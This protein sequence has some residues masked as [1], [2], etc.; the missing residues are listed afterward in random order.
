MSPLRQRM[1][2]DMQIRNFSPH[3]RHQYVT[4]VAA[5][6]KH[7]GKSPDQIGL[8]EIRSYQLFL[9][10]DKGV[11]PATLN[12]AVSALR[13]LYGVTLKQDWDIQMIPYA[14]KPKKLPVVLS[15]EEALRLLQVV[16]DMKYR[17]VL[18]ATYAAGLRVS[19]VTQLKVTDIDSGRMCIRVEQGKG[20]KDRYVMLSAKLLHHLRLYWRIYKPQ[21][22]LFEGRQNGHLPISTV[23]TVCKKA[24]IEAG[25][26]KEVTP[27]TL[28]HSFAT[29]LLEAG[30]D[31]RTIQFLL[32]HR[33]LNSTM[34]Y[35]HVAQKI[36]KTRSPL[37]LLPD[38]QDRNS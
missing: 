37:D 7:F 4:Y 32:G 16:R 34:I 11:C 15:Q 35:T 20:R 14:K 24:R 36:H 22:W 28:R 5:F 21:D 27:H 19:E 23:Q 1:I 38:V 13:F 29:H 18:M 2:E 10:Q 17:T 3:T 12:V 33:S 9:L 6:A 26:K 30:T 25:I 31:I 8:E